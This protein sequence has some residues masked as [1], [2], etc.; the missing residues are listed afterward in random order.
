MERVFGNGD[1]D[2]DIGGDAP[3][4]RGLKGM[5]TILCSTVRFCLTIALGFTSGSYPM[6]RASEFPAKLPMSPN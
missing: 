2:R 1:A 4:K 5:S 6:A 3:Q